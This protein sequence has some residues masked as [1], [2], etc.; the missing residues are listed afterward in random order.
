L[1]CRHS[2]RPGDQDRRWAT[3]EVDD[4]FHR[5]AGLN[6]S[7]GSIW[8]MDNQPRRELVGVDVVPS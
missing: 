6:M 5:L 7:S 2:E 8:A 4:R 1:V 3:Y